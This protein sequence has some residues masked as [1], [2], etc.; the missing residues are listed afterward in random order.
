MKVIK[1]LLI[2]ILMTSTIFTFSVSVFAQSETVGVSEGDW[3]TYDFGFEWYS[4]DP[5]M[6]IEEDEAF[7]YI[8]EGEFVRVEIKEIVDSNVTGEFTINYQNGTYEKVIGWVD[9]ITGEGEFSSWLIASGLKANDYIYSTEQEE[10]INETIMFDSCLGFRETNH[11]EHTFGNTT[12]EEYYNFGVNMYWDKEIGIIVE[13]SF[14]SE[15]MINGNLTTASGGWNI[16]DANMASI[17]EFSVLI[18]IGS[19]IMA[20]V[21]TYII[22]NRISQ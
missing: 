4:D 18:L 10:M 17:P 3:F 2:I 21:T 19:F 14:S 5:N 6:T 16:T 8:M 11:I 12:G 7:D 22:K 13:M 9:V 1:K 20:S 15:M